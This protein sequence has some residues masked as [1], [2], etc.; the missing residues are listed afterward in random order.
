MFVACLGS[1]LRLVFLLGG[2]DGDKLASG[3]VR[4]DGLGVPR[5]MLNKY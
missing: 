4:R 5:K 1:I 2:G 3:T